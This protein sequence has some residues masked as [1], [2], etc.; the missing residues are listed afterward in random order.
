MVRMW[1]NWNPCVMLVGNVKWR[2]HHGTFQQALK[3]LNTEL[4]YESTN[5][6]SRYIPKGNEKQRMRKILVLECSLQHYSQEP[7]GGQNS[8]AH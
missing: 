5:C 3:K 8:S 6:S 7:K 4:P 1:R 2:S